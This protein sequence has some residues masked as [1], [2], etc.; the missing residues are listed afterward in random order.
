[1]AAA[2]DAKERKKKRRKEKEKNM[3]SSK[4]QS[5]SKSQSQS[6]FKSKSEQ[7]KYD[8]YYYRKKYNNPLQRAIAK[9]I[10][11]I[12][13]ANSKKQQ[14]QEQDQQQQEEEEGKEEEKQEQ[15]TTTTID[16]DTDIDT[17]IN[18]ETLI[19]SI[20]RRYTIYP[21]LL[22]LPQHFF[23]VPTAWRDFIC[24]I[25]P[26]TSTTTATTTTDEEEEEEKEEEESRGLMLDKLYEA[27]VKEK[28]FEAQGIT[29]IA[30]NCPIVKNTTTT[31]DTTEEEVGVANIQRSPLNLKPLYGDFGPRDDSFLNGG[32]RRRR[33]R[34]ASPAESFVLG[35]QQQ[36]RLSGPDFESAFWVSTVQNDGIVQIWAPLWTM[37]SRGNIKEKAR[38]LGHGRPIRPFD[39]LDGV[40]GQLGQTL[41]EIAVLD[42]YVG[43]GYFAFSYLKRG[44]GKVVGWEINGWSIEGLRR[45]CRANGWK[46]KVITVGDDGDVCDEDGRTNDDALTALL[47][48]ETQSDSHIRLLAFWGDNKWALNVWQRLQRLTRQLPR[49]NEAVWTNVRHINL[50]LLPTS[51]PTW[52]MATDI[53]DSQ[54]GGWIHIHENVNERQIEA[55]SGQIVQELS[56]SPAAQTKRFVCSHIERVKTYA[57]EVMHCVF[58]VHVSPKKGVS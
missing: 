52:Q 38:I 3:H 19:H 4:S 23:S 41:E 37:F 11:T 34:E 10:T 17:D 29:H 1:M 32:R 18:I 48:Q 15:A 28:E 50:G 20:P 7:K 31:T 39:G 54:R 33:R 40:H 45:G 47:L 12:I 58:D 44:V 21:P 26:T 25:S 57:P 51:R 5:K 2:E 22:L 6:Q 8:Y 36:Q 46:I 16:I 35:R 49:G 24:A 43:I 14:Q 53:I 42:L 30:L 13:T 55:A 27:I 9:F 56:I